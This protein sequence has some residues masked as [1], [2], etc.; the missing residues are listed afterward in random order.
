MHAIDITSLTITNPPYLIYVCDLF[1]N[2]CQLVGTINIGDPIPTTIILPN[3]F[4]SAPGVTVKFIDSL[5]CEIS[6]IYYCD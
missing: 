3:Q 1:G 5:N 6:E 2:Q 4:N